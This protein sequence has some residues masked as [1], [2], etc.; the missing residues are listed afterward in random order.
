M[1]RTASEVIRELEMRVARLER[2]AKAYSFTD[3]KGRKVLKGDVVKALDD[4]KK[5]IVTDILEEFGVVFLDTSAGRRLRGE[6]VVK[7][8]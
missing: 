6:E 2:Q 4:R 3:A 8:G 1:R 7:V 5:Y